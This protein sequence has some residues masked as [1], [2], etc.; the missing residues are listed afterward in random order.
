MDTAAL[1]SP[2]SLLDAA[3]V[4]T[5]LAAWLGIGWWIENP[6]PS[7]P[8]TSRIV[9]RYRREWMSEM[10]TRE[11][12]IFDSQILTSLRESTSFFGSAVMIAIGGGLALMGDPSRLAGLVPDFG[13]GTPPEHV[14]TVKLTLPVLLLV[15]A[16]LA[17]VWS[18]RLFGYCA[19]V[20]ASVPNDADAPN[21]RP[22]A[23]KAAEVNITAARSFNRGLRA[24]YFAL[25]ALVWLAGAVPLMLATAM[26]CVVLW[27]REFASKSRQVLLRPDID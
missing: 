4:A 2:F 15:S 24:V 21:A 1:L 25:A 3:A 14:W 13:Q 5:L 17:F 11:P 27:R 18:N 16:F 20:M 22:R 26:T 19:V 6:R 10:V 12:R 9:S 23:A 7:R 8:S